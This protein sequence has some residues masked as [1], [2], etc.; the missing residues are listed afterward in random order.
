MDANAATLLSQIDPAELGDRLRAARM[1]KGWT[2]TDVAGDV[3]SVGYVSRI[4]S[5]QRRPNAAVLQALAIRLD[6]PVDQLLRG[7]SAREQ[8]EIRL[9]LDFAELSLENGDHVEAE[10]RACESRDRA[11]AV[12]RHDLADRAQFLIARALEA[13]GNIDDAILELEPLV[14]AI[15]VGKPG[16]ATPDSRPGIAIPRVQAAIALSRCYRV[17]GDLHLAIEVGERVLR[18]LEGTPLES[19]DEGVQLA[20]TVAAA[21]NDR[22]D[23]GQAVRIGRTAIAK[24]ERLG[25]PKARASAY[26]NASIFESERGSVAE[27]IPLAERALALL[28]EGRDGRNLAGL[29]MALADMQLRL[30]PPELAAAQRQLDLAAADLSGSS[31]GTLDR[32]INDVYRAR[33]LLLSGDF[34]GAVDLLADVHAAV[35]ASAP[36]TAADAKALEGQ[37]HAAAGYLDRAG[38]SYREAV[39]LLTAA[40]ADREAAQQW[41]EL[42][43]LLEGVGAYDEARAAYRSAAASAGLRSRPAIPRREAIPA[44][45]A[46]PASE[47]ARGAQ[48]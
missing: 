42:A 28:A 45:A 47:T 16:P 13:Q 2:Q 8:D 36:L 31:A 32:A 10:M 48:R 46:I 34:S 4:E 17:S 11:R 30:D 38:Q 7:E 12:A 18:E 37:A 15:P 43:S 1:A 44:V 3:V 23:T 27:A 9:S 24:A 5:G 14:A 21:Y 41:Y 29:R 19:T 40:G 20:V 39:L 6:V 33:A 22:G 26:W 25:T 35:H